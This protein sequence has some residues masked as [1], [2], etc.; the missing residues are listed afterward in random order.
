MVTSTIPTKI[1][2]PLS[3]NDETIQLKEM[4]QPHLDESALV[5]L[6]QLLQADVFPLE[7]FIGEITESDV[8]DGTTIN[9]HFRFIKLDGNGRPMIK[10]LAEQMLYHLASYVTPRRRIN[11]PRS[12]GIKR[13]QVL[14][15][16]IH[17]EAK[18]LF[19]TNSNT[20]EGGEFLLYLIAEK[21]LGLP[22]VLCKMALKTSGNVHV[23]GTDGIHAKYEKESGVLALYWG[24]S[25]LHATV[26]SAIDKC[27]E[28]V[29]PF[30]LDEGTGNDSQGR[31]LKLF[32]DN[33]GDNIDDPELAK[34][35]LEYIDPAHANY[36]KCEYRAVCLIGFDNTAYPFENSKANVEEL[37]KEF[38]KQVSEW[39]SKLSES[40]KKHN[41]HTFTIEAFC[42]PFPSVQGFR[43]SFLEML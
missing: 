10:Q 24:E 16:Q 33:A 28:S 23:H 42:L 13:Q 7:N 9:V 30:L 38:L 14:M 12:L 25:K 40:I 15:T 32:R 31:D 35:L 29:A 37:K 34:A 1:I 4:E 21:F 11:E 18:R 41:I 5:R 26:N 19:V 17:E 22:Q 2:Q 8:L 36:S 43:D 3:Q 6:E 39:R 27:F 20:G